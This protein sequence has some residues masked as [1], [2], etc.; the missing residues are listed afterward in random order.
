MAS[1]TITKFHRLINEFGF[2]SDR[3]NIE[4]ISDNVMDLKIIISFLCVANSYKIH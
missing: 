2:F 3:N 4:V 1:F